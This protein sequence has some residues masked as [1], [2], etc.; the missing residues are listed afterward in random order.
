MQGPEA[1]TEIIH[2][3]CVAR[4]GRGLL[5]LGASGQGKS[6]LAL[7]LMALGADLVADDRVVLRR[8]PDAVIA[9][10]PD[11][12][13][14]LVEARGVGLL[15]AESVGPVA[16]ALVV[17]LDQVETERLPALRTTRLLGRDVPLLHGIDAPHFAPALMQYLKAGLRTEA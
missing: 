9:D 3:S 13:R 1:P 11:P 10:A 8:H 16:L 12:I 2:A 5:I 14:G 7:T 4:E 17:D 6:T 15:K